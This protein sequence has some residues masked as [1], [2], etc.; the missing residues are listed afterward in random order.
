M[1]KGLLKLI[2]SCSLLWIAFSLQATT[3]RVGFTGSSTPVNGVDY[4]TLQAAHDASNNGDTI[5]VYP[6]TIINT[7]NTFTGTISKQ[8]V[9]I[10]PGYLYNNYYASALGSQTSLFNSGLQ[11]LSGYISSVNITIAKGSSGTIISGINGLSITTVN[12][13]DALNNITV[14][15]CSNL[16]ISWNNSGICDNWFITQCFNFRI[17][18]SSVSNVISST[19]NR[20][21]TNF[22]I[23]NCISGVSYYT[24]QGPI[25]G[26][27]G[28][29]L[30]ISPVGISS[31]Q[32]LN[33]TFIGIGSTPPYGVYSFNNAA[34]VI[35]NCFLEYG[36][37]SGYFAG[38]ANTIFI[39][40]MTTQPQLNNIMYTNPGSAN[41]LFAASTANNAIFLGY[42]NNTSGGLT[43]YAP[44]A[45]FQ[46]ATTS[47]A[48]GIGVIPGTLTATDC[49]AY[50]GTN[51]Y[52]ASG[53]PSV[54]AF[55][56]LLSPSATASGSTYSVTFSVR[57]NN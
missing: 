44:D 24:S 57:G 7:G 50:G 53:I 45:Q 23:E 51:P 33:C 22:R 32:I 52:K 39:N 8:L 27:Y 1:K 28:I 43:Q 31:G 47:P 56:K 17:T 11:N 20:A 34:V 35:Q 16:N 18:Q 6:A 42:P 29:T 2:L 21:I 3:R 49:G 9:I 30:D 54:P 38:A 12:T 5:Q 46:L 13:L 36:G 15:R 48:K 14:T 41:N 25:G 26:A 40:N 19:A 55:Y 37:A 4:T 10:G